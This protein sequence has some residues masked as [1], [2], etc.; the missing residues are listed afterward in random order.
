MPP[1]EVIATKDQTKALTEPSARQ[2]VKWEN[3]FS[4]EGGGHGS[5]VICPAGVVEPQGADGYAGEGLPALGGCLPGGGG[6]ASST[7]AT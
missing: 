2:W 6:G 4:R 5:C 1:P 3:K 7:L